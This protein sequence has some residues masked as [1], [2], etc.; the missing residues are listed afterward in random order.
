MK[1]IGA[2]IAAVIAEPESDAVKAKVKR[3]VAELTARFPM[4][5]TTLKEEAN[6]AG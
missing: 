6:S 5:P 1:L 4:Y 3:D 2:M